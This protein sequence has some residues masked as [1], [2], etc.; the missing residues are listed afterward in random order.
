MTMRLIITLTLFILKMIKNVENGG[1]YHYY[2][3]Y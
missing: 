1:S 2:Y 3:G